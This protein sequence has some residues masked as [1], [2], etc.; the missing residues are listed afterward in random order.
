MT[1]LNDQIRDM[2]GNEIDASDN[3]FIGVLED[4]EVE[5]GIFV[6]MNGGEGL[7]FYETENMFIVGANTAYLPPLAGQN[8]MIRI[9]LDDVAT[10]I[11]KA[12]LDRSNAPVYNLQ[13]QRVVQPQKGLYIQGGRK[14]VLK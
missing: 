11:E 1:F 13:G 9:N 10:A 12:E 4:T 14:V 8:G 3:A 2:E 6:L 7:G 5:P